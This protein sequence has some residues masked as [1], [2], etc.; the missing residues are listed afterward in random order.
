MI[1]RH[2]LDGGADGLAAYRAIAADAPRLL[3]PGGHL[4][5]EIGAGQEREVERTAH[6]RGAC[7][8]R[9]PARSVGYR[10]RDRGHSPGRIGDI[11][12]VAIPKAKKPLGMSQKTD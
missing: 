9:G 4:V 3:G 10:A 11:T 6:R 5:V 12:E 1:R 8:R 2:A 7:N